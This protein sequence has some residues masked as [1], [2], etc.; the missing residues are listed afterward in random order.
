MSAAPRVS[1]LLPTRNRARLLRQALRSVQRQT[2]RD[3]EI[4]VLDDGSADETPAVLAAAA[5]ADARIR[6]ARN[7]EPSGLP[8]ALNRLL[9]LASGEWVARMD[10]DD[11]CLPS[12]L[13]TQL[14]FASEHHLDVCGSWYRRFGW[15][16]GGVGRPPKHDEAIKAGLLFQPPILHPSVLMRRAALVDAGGYST[17]YL[18]AQDYE[19]WTRLAAR[20]ARFGNVPRVL[21]R[22]RVSRHQVSRKSN[23]QQAHYAQQIRARYLAAC[24][25]PAEPA[26]VDLHVRVREPVPIRSLDELRAFEAWLLVLRE[27]FRDAPVAADVVARQWLF[28]GCRA[29]GLGMSCWRVWRASPL[30]AAT[31]G[32]KAAVLFGL[33]AGRVEYRSAPY[34]LLEPFAPA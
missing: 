27:H 24:G 13:G 25:I 33:C 6:V 12:R 34:R 15:L 11:L 16:P 10:D 29:A 23:A 1:V 28:V 5:R 2:L 4:L 31:S 19:L 32:R 3:L 7:D 17:A 26:Q 22:Y 21:L 8:A 20:G 30:A 18:H 14:A 9:E